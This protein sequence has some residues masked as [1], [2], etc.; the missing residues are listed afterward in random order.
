MGSF[1]H[2]VMAIF[3]ALDLDF[4]RIKACCRTDHLL[5]INPCFICRAEIFTL[6]L[7]EKKRD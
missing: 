5:G 6:I 1:V 7:D 3:E 4:K 2:L